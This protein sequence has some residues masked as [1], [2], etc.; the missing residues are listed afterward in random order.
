MIYFIHIHKT[1]GTTLKE[2]FRNN[3]WKNAIFINNPKFPNYEFTK[4]QYKRIFNAKRNIQAIESHNIRFPLPDS[5]F[6]PDIKPVVFVRNPFDR[7]LSNYYYLQQLT[8]NKHHSSKPVEDYLNYVTNNFARDVRYNNGQTYHLAKCF[9][10][11]K[12]KAVLDKCFCVGITG[13]FDESLLIF[14]KKWVKILILDMRKKTLA[15]RKSKNKKRLTRLKI[16]QF[17]T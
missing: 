11:E 12:A 8:D 7:F 6:L 4:S 10:V 14:K 5:L 17:T 2:I 15:G 16:L 1:G 13:Y 9:D 3:F